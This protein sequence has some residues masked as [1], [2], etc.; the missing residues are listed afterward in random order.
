MPTKR[1]RKKPVKRKRKP[2]KRRPQKGKGVK[3]TMKKYATKKNI[4]GALGA[5]LVAGQIH[6]YATHP[7]LPQKQYAW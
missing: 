3:S 7:S 4:L 1:A 2:V 6:G 5:L